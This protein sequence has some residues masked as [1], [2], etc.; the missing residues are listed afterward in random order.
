[1]FGYTEKDLCIEGLDKGSERIH[2]PEYR[3]VASGEGLLPSADGGFC[4]LVLLPRI[5]SV[6]LSEQ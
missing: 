5:I 2:N 4:M 3:T 1:M 6:R